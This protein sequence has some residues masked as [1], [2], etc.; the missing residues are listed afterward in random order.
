MIKKRIIISILIF[1]CLVF[2]CCTSME[3][4]EWEENKDYYQILYAY[5]KDFFYDYDVIT[6]MNYEHKVFH[7]LSK[8]RS[9]N[10]K[11]P[12]EIYERIKNGFYYKLKINK[13]DSIVVLKSRSNFRVRGSPIILDE[14]INDKII[15][16]WSED[17][18]RV[19][20]YTSENIFGLYVEILE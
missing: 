1:I 4:K 19:P 11:P 14:K 13:I 15:P 18:L 2:F 10:E 8:E 5:E 3:W 9:K 20:A 17:T 6:L 12:F 16:F 7:V